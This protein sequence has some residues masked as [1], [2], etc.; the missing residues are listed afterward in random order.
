MPPVTTTSTSPVRIIE[1]AISTARIEDAQTLLIVSAGVSFGRPAAIG[2]C[3]AGAWPAPAYSTWPMITYCGSCG[4]RPIRSSAPRMAIA[5]S[6]GASR[7]ARPPPSLPKGV[8]TAETITDR[9]IGKTLASELEAGLEPAGEGS[10]E[11]HGRLDV[12]QRDH[13]AGRVDVPRR[14]RDQPRRDARAAR[15]GRVHVGVRVA[16]RDVDGVADSFRLGRLDQQLEDPRVDRRAAVDDRAPAKPGLAVDLRVAVG[17][18]GRASDVHRERDLRLERED[19]RAR[20][21]EVA[22]LLLHCRHRGHVARSAARF[23]DAPGRLERD[24]GT[25]PVSSERD[26]SRPPATSTGSVASTATSPIC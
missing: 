9:D 25:E 12:V 24:E 11:L 20:A 13:L 4:S 1:S 16:C 10:D 23:G 2:P 18:V 19:R 21:T 14:E 7:D 17:D 6:S 5:P 22:D 8:R 3:R 15:V 26:T